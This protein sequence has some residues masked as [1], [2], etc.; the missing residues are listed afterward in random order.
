MLRITTRIAP[1]KANLLLEG[2]L[3][4]I[5]VSELFDAWR[6]LNRQS[7]SIDLSGLQRVD[8]AGEYLLALMRS[9]GAELVGSGLVAGDLIQGIVR[10]WPGGTKCFA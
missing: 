4:G 2:E 8:K 9:N 1:E 3:A 5:W 10:D 7:L 6:D